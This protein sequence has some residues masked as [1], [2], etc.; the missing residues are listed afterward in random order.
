[1]NNKF[2]SPKEASVGLGVSESSLKRWCDAGTIK[3]SKTAGGHRK[4]ALAD[5]VLFLRTTGTVAAKPEVLG[6]PARLSDAADRATGIAHLTTALEQGDADATRGIVAGAYIRGVTAAELGDAWLQPALARI[7]DDWQCGRIDVYQEHRASNL[8]LRSLT[9]LLAWVDAASARGPRA[10]LAACAGDHYT[11]ALA[12][13]ELVLREHGW[14][15][16]MLGADTPTASIVKAI[17]E[18]RPHLV[19]VSINT[20][21][22]DTAWVALE[23]T[24]ASEAVPLLVAGRARP[25][26]S[27]YAR[28][29]DSMAALAA[30]LVQTGASA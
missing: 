12:C 13:A 27:R 6:L 18:L 25:V 4:I 1:M 11:I 22:D 10:L 7:G 16:I 29:C 21:L 24:A 26:A 19:S 9:E 8:I 14:G 17:A 2:L 28:P 5:I 3:T 15:A 30:A 20:P 23:T